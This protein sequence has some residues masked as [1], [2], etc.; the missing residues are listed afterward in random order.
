MKKVT[1]FSIAVLSAC[2][3]SVT[4]PLQATAETYYSATVSQPVEGDVWFRNVGDGTDTLSYENGKWV[5]EMS[6]SARRKTAYHQYVVN[7][8]EPNTQ[9]IS[10]AQAKQDA[11]IDSA[12]KNPSLY[13]SLPD[14]ETMSVYA[15]RVTDGQIFKGTVRIPKVIVPNQVP[16]KT[17]ST[18]VNDD[19]PVMLSVVNAGSATD[20]GSESGSESSSSASSAESNTSSSA[21]Q[22][23]S[24]SSTLNSNS[25]DTSSAN[26]ST[27][28][29][30][31]NTDNQAQNDGSS[32]AT[33]SAVKTTTDN[34]ASATTKAAKTT[35]NSTTPTTTK[36]VSVQSSVAS[37]DNS[38]NKSNSQASSSVSSTSA[39]KKGINNML[40][41]TDEAKSNL[42]T[43]GILTMLV[44]M[45]GFI[46]I[47]RY[48]D[49]S[50]I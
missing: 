36:T 28:S 45:I 31:T 29:S 11:Y 46:S 25:V 7:I 22:S 43:F 14:S 3:I 2:T 21:T 10:E 17:A 1:L 4:T 5:L 37:S 15:M 13:Q 18:F 12:I 8:Y 40:P 26:S 35:T 24:E 32:T 41:Q 34:T 33:T 44:S 50:K 42:V 49:G 38:N 6:D 20:S 39:I 9:A 48:K 23:S 47:F 27:K 19:V 30:K 16:I